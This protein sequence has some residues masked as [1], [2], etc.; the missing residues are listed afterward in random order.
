MEIIDRL[1]EKGEE[2][3]VFGQLIHNPTVLDDLEARGIDCIDSLD[4]IDPSKKLIIRTHGIPV[5]VE[6]N[7]DRQ[8]TQRVDATCP[9]VKKLQKEIRKL[10]DQ[11]TLIVIAGDREHPEI[12]AARSYAE[13]TN[14]VVINSIEEA[15]RIPFT[16]NIS[17]VAQTTLDADF[18]DSLVSILETKTEHLT[19]HNTICRATRVRQEAIKKLAPKVDFVVVVG[20]K[21]SSNTKKLYNIALKRNKYSFHIE[22][23]SELQD[24]GF[25]RQVADFQSVGITAG[26]STPPQEIEKIKRFFINFNDST[27]KVKEMNHGRSKRHT[28]TGG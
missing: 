4:H 18:F 2:I 5:D 8:N 17:V 14:V 20:G 7:L 27:V 10:N 21:N 16:P 22:D 3:H 6:N 19:V 1:H 26:A 12:A 15:Q 13:D 28:I 25:I 11:E 23:S 24:P 9:L